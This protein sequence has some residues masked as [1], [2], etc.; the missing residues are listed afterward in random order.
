MSHPR[1]VFTFTLALALSASFALAEPV[2]MNLWPGK[3]PGE[4]EDIGE[5][6][7]LPKRPDRRDVERLANVS[8]PTLTVY[9]PAKEKDTGAA[10][11]ICPG[12]GYHIL[13]IDHEGRMVAK[14]L[15]EHGVTGILL[16]YRVPR[17]K[18]RPKHEAPLQ[19]AQRAMSLA[20]QHAKEWKIDP[21]RIGILG[22]SAGGH[23]AAATATNF[24]KRAYESIDEA[25]KLSC[26]PDLAV[27]IYPGYI[28]GEDGEI[29]EELTV[30]E[31]TP[32]MFLAH[33]NDDRLTPINSVAMYLAL[34]KAKVSAELHVYAKGGHGFGMDLKDHPAAG[35]PNACA[36]WLK[37]Q[38]WLKKK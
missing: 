24:D 36:A 13:A 37:H 18:D 32:P 12:G 8:N 27:L 7:L 34:R 11:V 29:S 19:D 30:N 9:K 1:T 16:K 10:V 14:F 25:D 17:R 33:A 26:R 5:E 28:A 4:T 3:A 6:H 22:F 2:T 23:L 38:G 35:W 20:R 15:N 21:N 31:K